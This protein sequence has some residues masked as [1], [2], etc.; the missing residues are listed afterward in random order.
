MLPLP[1]I[2]YHRVR[3]VGAVAILISL[4]T[5]AMQLTGIVAACPYCAVQRTVIGLLGILMLIPHR[6]WGVHYAASVAAFF[7]AA[8]AAAQHINGWMAIHKG[9]F[10]GFSPLYG[11]GFLLSAAALAIIIGQ[12]MIL[13]G[14]DGDTGTRS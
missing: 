5:W 4:A 7:G 12:W 3:T 8:T 2:L 14:I 11:N 1:S 9:E 13:R 6:S 10:H